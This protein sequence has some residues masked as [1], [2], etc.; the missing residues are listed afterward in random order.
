ML[1]AR[2]H[3]Q[4]K[5]LLQ[6]DRVAWP[7][8][9][10][11]SRLIA[12]GLRRGDRALIQLTPGSE[13][14]WWLGLLV[15]LCLQRQDC[16]LVLEEEQRQRLLQVE[17]PRLGAAGL[18]LPCWQGPEAPSGDQLWLL[19]TGELVQAHRRGQLAEH[20]LLLIPE[21]HQLSR[22]LRRAL[23]LTL[24]TRDWEHLRQAHPNADAALL[25]L[26]ERLSR[27]L[28]RQATRRDATVRLEG[29]R[30]Q[31]LRDLLSLLSPLPQPWAAVL[32]AEAG[33]WASWASL[34]HRLLLWSWHMQLLEPF[35]Q[36]NGLLQQRP[37]ILISSGGEADPLPTEL[38]RAGFEAEVIVHL[39]EPTLL[40]PVPLFAPR[41]QPLPNTEVFAQHLLEQSRRLI[42]G[43]T[44][45]TV[46][47]LDDTRLRR[48][49]TSEL[50]AEFGSR[51]IEEHT[52]PEVNGVICCHWEW[53]LQHQAQLP[54]PEQLIIGL[55]P[56]ASLE[57]P[58]TAARVEAFKRQGRDWFR[59]LLLPE[60]LS[61]LAPAV[62]PL[63]RSGGR[64]AVLDGRVRGRSWGE[65]VFAALQPWTPLQRLL[66]D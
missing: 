33:H 44:G 3:Q 16:V 52:A 54:A 35:E 66:P 1:E 56:I 34:D 13:D 2:A 18:Q 49:L 23:A 43:R 19:T 5:T 61:L 53:W 15:P 36:L 46:I 12:R 20:H 31:T 24:E 32:E 9:L 6:H 47:L 4:L 59:E 58:L 41:R 64:L 10:T 26:H 17:R 50:S 42:L 14:H 27:Q 29:G 8:H 7:H 40:E 63:R 48:G 45:L 30:L 62:A 51:V 21:A 38:N 25:D 37:A 55:L 39:R 11:L 65:Q 57:Q 22:R 60:A 28:F